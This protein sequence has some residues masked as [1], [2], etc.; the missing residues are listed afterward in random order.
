MLEQNKN[1]LEFK[2]IS[3]VLSDE[4]K[5]KWGEKCIK[6]LQPVIEN[7]LP[8]EIYNYI[9][10]ARILPP[11][12]LL[13]KIITPITFN[14]TTVESFDI[15]LNSK[16]GSHGMISEYRIHFDNMSVFKLRYLFTYGIKN[17]KLSSESFTDYIRNETW[18]GK[19]TDEE[20]CE[21][22][23]LLAPGIKSFF[24]QSKIEIESGKASDQAYILA[25]DS[26]AIKFE[27]L[28]R[29]FSLKI[30]AQ[31]IELYQDGT[32]SRISFEKL[33]EN[34]KLQG[35]IE[36]QDIAF[37]KFLFTDAGLNI[38]N[39]IAHCFYQFSDYSAA[40]PMF[41]IVAILRLGAYNLIPVATPNSE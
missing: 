18:I 16:P 26:L 22:I 23:S 12:F 36:D 8:Y 34:P 20:S 9:S 21:W 13:N 32:S 25:S 30:G 24:E 6:L 38:R 10:T 7:H 15:N 31:T 19:T 29:A 17:G 2:S 40:F 35:T 33:L 5:Q 3:V 28:L 11:A 1:H 27:G 4:K 37:F 41:L 14:Y 39:N